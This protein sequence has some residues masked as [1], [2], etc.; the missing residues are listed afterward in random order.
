MNNLFCILGYIDPN[1]ITIFLASLLTIIVVAFI[2]L[3]PLVIVAIVLFFVFKSRK[4]K[5]QSANNSV[6][7]IH[8]AADAI[9]SENQ[10]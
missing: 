10:N 5:A 9:S 7:D 4:K 6:V 8:T 2:V 3:L 1:S